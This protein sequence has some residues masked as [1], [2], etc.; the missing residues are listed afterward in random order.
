[1]EAEQVRVPVAAS[2]P[3]V[4]VRPQTVEVPT[5][6]HVDNYLHFGIEAGAS[7]IHL[8]VH[9]KP[10]WRLHGILRPIWDTADVLTHA[11][12]ERLAMSFLD[13]AH[14]KRLQEKGDVDFA[15]QNG[16]ARFRASVV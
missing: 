8:G 16:E 10:I 4:S 7:D 2:S 5:L 14:Q 12:T 6:K 9:A 1:M 15:Y 13:E 3:W 11:D